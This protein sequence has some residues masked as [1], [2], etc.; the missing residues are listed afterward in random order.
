[1]KLIIE[2]GS[3]KT[4][5]QL[6]SEG[7][8]FGKLQ[9]TT[10]LNPVTDKDY[11]HKLRDLCARYTDVPLKTIYYYGSGCI[12][13]K[14][15]TAVAETIKD[16]LDIEK[17]HVADDLIG[18]ARSVCGRNKGIA[19]ILGTGSNIGFYDGKKIVDTIASC[20]YLLGDEGSGFR[21]GQKI[22]LAFARK[23]LDE[24]IM[25]KIEFDSG[26]DRSDAIPHLYAQDNSRSF[27]ASF[28]KYIHEMPAA[29]HDSILGEVFDALIQNLILELYD[30]HQCPVHFV[31]SIAHHFKDFLKQKL[32]KFNIIA[33]RIEQT[34]IT[35]LIEYHCHE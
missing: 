22:Y 3:S 31:G 4:D 18:A 24:V 2:A 30:R 7:R 21:K 11:E 27:L 17:I 28:S 5:S 29:M 25:Q 34:P 23:R 35:G 13:S 16:V 14:I 26:I 10:G 8:I 32:H 9:K 19:C 6:I 1:M 12:N 33:G 15:N 20:G